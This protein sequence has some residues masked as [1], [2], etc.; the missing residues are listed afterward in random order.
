MLDEYSKCNFCHYHD[1]FDGCRAWSCSNYDYY[2][3]NK[4]RIVEKAKEVGIS[5]TDVIA[6]IEIGD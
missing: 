2:K 3:P 4:N 1:N 5:V 6:L